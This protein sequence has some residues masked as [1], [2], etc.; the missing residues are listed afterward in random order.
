MVQ[1]R[2]DIYTFPFEDFK[3]FLWEKCSLFS[4]GWCFW[5]FLRII[6]AKVTNTPVNKEYDLAFE[7][8]FYLLLL[9]G[10]LKILQVNETKLK[11][12]LNI[13]I[14]NAYTYN[15]LISN[16]MSNGIVSI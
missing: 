8:E 12:H 10:F 3:V 4:Y 2:V 6:L 15:K 7:F 11:K 14:A 1:K 5:Q 9:T 16:V 13:R